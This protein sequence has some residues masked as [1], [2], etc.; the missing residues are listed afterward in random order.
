VAPGS[1]VVVIV[2]VRASGE[3]DFVSTAV[4]SARAADGSKP[5]A[6]A[7][8]TTRGVRHPPALALRRPTGETFRIDRNN[9]IQWTL[10]G[11]AGGV[12]IDLSRDDGASWERLADGVENVG[13]YDWTGTGPV[14]PSAR[15]R[16]TSITR[17]QLTQTSASFAVAGR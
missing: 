3:G 5:E 12:R 11:V 4:V 9:T 14:T 15:I 1:E 17:P 2:T 7:L 16:V 6:S 13:Y 10:R 8:T